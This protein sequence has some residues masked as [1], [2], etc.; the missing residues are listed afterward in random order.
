MPAPIVDALDEYAVRER[1]EPVSRHLATVLAT[2]VASFHLLTA[3][4]LN[5]LSSRLNTRKG[6]VRVWTSL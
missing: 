1:P 2:G 6:V 3:G 4:I 5:G